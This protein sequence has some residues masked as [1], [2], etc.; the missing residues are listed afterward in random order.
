VAGAQRRPPGSLEDKLCRNWGRRAWTPSFR[1]C[2][3]RFGLIGLAAL[4]KILGMT[5]EPDS[6]RTAFN[7]IKPKKCVFKG[8]VIGPNPRYTSKPDM[9]T[10]TNV[11]M[12]G[13][14]FASGGFSLDLMMQ[15]G[16]GR[17][18]ARW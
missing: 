1:I 12:I 10:T 6:F 4:G 3:R 14:A 2:S 13:L 8:A 15:R 11:N 16:I 17:H 7:R 18:R 9:N 5:P